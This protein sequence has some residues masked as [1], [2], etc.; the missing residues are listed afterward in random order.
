MGQ[1]SRLELNGFN[2]AAVQAAWLRQ[3]I[4]RESRLF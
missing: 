1:K 4:A 2:I 3:L